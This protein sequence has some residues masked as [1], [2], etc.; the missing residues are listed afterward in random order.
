MIRD[1]VCVKI[2]ICS[3]IWGRMY[4]VWCCISVVDW[5]F[6]VSLESKKKKTRVESKMKHAEN[7]LFFLIELI[8]HKKM[9]LPLYK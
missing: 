6:S 9:S 5:S 4:D 8:N 7:I 3:F 2:E 1:F